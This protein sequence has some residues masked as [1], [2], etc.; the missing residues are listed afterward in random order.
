MKLYLVQ[1]GEATTKESDPER[2]LTEK[3][4]S[5]INQLAI[6]LNHAGITAKQVIHSGQ[7]R[8]QQTAE[9]LAMAIAPDA[10]QSR[11]EHL[12]PNDAPDTIAQQINSWDED[13]LIVGHLPFMAK[14]VSRLIFGDESQSIVS[15]Q[16]GAL[17]CL[18][19]NQNNN[20]AILWALRPEILC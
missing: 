11:N 4:R 19:R 12:N 13:T 8:A 10:M 3:G 18:E 7:L 15:F 9:D 16:P 20:W 17:V 6:F 1:H 2:P 14:L 5:D